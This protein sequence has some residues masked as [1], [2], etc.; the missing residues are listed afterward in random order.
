M[1]KKGERPAVLPPRT[2]MHT[3]LTSRSGLRV[4]QPASSIPGASCQCVLGES[5]ALLAFPLPLRVRSSHLG[6]AGP[7]LPIAECFASSLKGRRG[8]GSGSRTRHPHQAPYLP[9]QVGSGPL[10][11]PCRAEPLPQSPGRVVA[12]PGPG[13]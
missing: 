3:C 12:K 11:P 2:E 8:R 5:P 6:T 13:P 1:G 9:H 7:L 4:A 10:H